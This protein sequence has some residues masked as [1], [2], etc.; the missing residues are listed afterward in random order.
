MVTV[1]CLLVPFYHY[2]C[3]VLGFSYV[4][5]NESVSKVNV[6]SESSDW[7]FNAKINTYSKNR[8]TF[9]TYSG[10]SNIASCN[11]QPI[12]VL[13]VVNSTAYFRNTK[14]H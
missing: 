10:S 8:F 2:I 11:K 1:G 3:L 7:T 6:Q 14:K 9:G 12:L 13:N 4:A 5:E